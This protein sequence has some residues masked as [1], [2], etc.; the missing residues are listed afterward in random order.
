MWRYKFYFFWEGPHT[1]PAK[2]GSLFFEWWHHAPQI[3]EVK[4]NGSKKEGRKA[5][6]GVKWYIIS[7]H[8]WQSITNGITQVWNLSCSVVTGPERPLHIR[9]L[10]DVR[11]RT[12][13]S[14][15]YLDA[16]L[17]LTEK[18][19]KEKKTCK[20]NHG[21]RTFH[22]ADL[23]C[24]RLRSNNGRRV[25]QH[26]TDHACHILKEAAGPERRET[27]RACLKFLHVMWWNVGRVNGQQ[28]SGT[29]QKEI[30]KRI[31]RLKD[32]TSAVRTSSRMRQSRSTG[33]EARACGTLSDIHHM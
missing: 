19:T 15:K 28:H 21:L 6:A 17:N 18:P 4:S 1:R 27:V 25:S 29:Y 10:G 30:L 16:Q 11:P 13:F 31:T 23:C 20:P 24:F 26:M 12:A 5:G 22:D 3:C 8:H 33:F 9:F 32:L 2:A 14:V 7:Q